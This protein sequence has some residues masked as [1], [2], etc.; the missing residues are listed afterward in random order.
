M[1]HGMAHG[2]ACKRGSLQH[3]LKSPQGIGRDVDVGLS[4]L[5][6]RSEAWAF[7]RLSVSASWLSSEF[8]A[9]GATAKPSGD[10]ANSLSDYQLPVRPSGTGW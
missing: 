9:E 5:S 3:W 7:W 1:A 8:P 4:S 6:L 10:I 2:L